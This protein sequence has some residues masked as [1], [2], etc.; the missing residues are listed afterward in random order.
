M[1]HDEHTMFE[2]HMF[3]VFTC[4]HIQSSEF[5]LILFQLFFT[6]PIGTAV[7]PRGC[8]DGDRLGTVCDH[9]DLVGGGKP[10]EGPAR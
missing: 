5:C 3:C 8:L 10:L 4:F 1:E 7:T 9:L 6:V 2:K